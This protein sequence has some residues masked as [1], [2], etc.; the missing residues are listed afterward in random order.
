MTVK[1]DHLFDKSRWLDG[2]WRGEPDRV[3]WVDE[4]ARLPCLVMRHPEMG[5]LCGYVGV[6]PAHPAWG[7]HY[8]GIT[9]ADANEKARRWNRMMELSRDL[10][11][12]GLEFDEAW[13]VGH[14]KVSEDGWTPEPEG[15]GEK[16]AALTAHGGLTFAGHGED[17]GLPGFWLY[18]FDCAHAG[19]MT[20]FVLPI[21][22]L[23][24][25]LLRGTYRDVTYVMDECS[26][27]AAQ[28]AALAGE[29]A[30]QCEPGRVNHE[31]G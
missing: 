25:G 12:K 16:V 31:P 30:S 22:A 11:G 26:N 14:R 3:E 18:G 5:N 1:A 23:A 7:L 2:P 9:M 27:L 6:P 15:I 20:D 21:P 28:L 17:M 4:G 8:D 29:R 13:T 24:R 19:D 10:R